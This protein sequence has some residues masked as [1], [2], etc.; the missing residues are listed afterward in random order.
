MLA[1]FIQAVAVSM[2][3]SQSFASLWHLLSQANVRSTTHRRGNTSKPFAISERLMI[4]TVQS[5]ILPSALRNFGP[6]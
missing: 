4:S 2:D 1:M 3:F 5:P 6:A